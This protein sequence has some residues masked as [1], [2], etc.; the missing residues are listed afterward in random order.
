MAGSLIHSRQKG[1]T[2]I[3]LMVSVAIVGILA[4][5]AFPS[6]TATLQRQQLRSAVETLVSDIRLARTR[7]ESHGAA[8]ASLIEFE[9]A[10]G[11]AKTWSYTGVNSVSGTLLSRSDSDFSYD[12]EMV[13]SDFGDADADGNPDMT[14]TTIRGFDSDGAGAVQLSVGSFSA[15]VSRNLLGMVSVCSD[16]ALGYSSCGS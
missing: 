7:A 10:S 9:V 16:G 5:M 11:D 1:L 3:E 8:G 4:A 6:F 13:V 2:M 14:F 12:I 15:T